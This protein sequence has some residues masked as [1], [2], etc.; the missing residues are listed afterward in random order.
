MAA[1]ELSRDES[2]K[3]DLPHVCIV[4]GQAAGFRCRRFLSRNPWWVYLGIPFGL[5]PFFVLALIAR[6]R[7][8][9]VAP[10]CELHRYHWLWRDV[11]SYGWLV[12]SV[13]LFAVA[14]MIFSEA[15]LFRG[16][17]IHSDDVAFV[18]FL[19]LLAGYLGLLAWPF[20]ALALRQSGVHLAGTTPRTTTLSDV[21]VEFVEAVRVRRLDRQSA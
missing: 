8:L 2:R 18:S 3:G 19:L 5:L 4:C 17:S 20:V 16:K 9:V 13:L 11:V 10:V 15:I 6:Q 7:R 21:P 1:V 14:L 12:L